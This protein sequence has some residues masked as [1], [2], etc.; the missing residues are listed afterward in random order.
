MTAGTS[1]CV[2]GHGAACHAVSLRLACNLF[3]V[4]E[5]A[6]RMTFAD[7]IEIEIFFSSLLVI[8]QIVEA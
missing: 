2:L 7:C 1:M 6:F 4:S 3:P 8:A 5:K